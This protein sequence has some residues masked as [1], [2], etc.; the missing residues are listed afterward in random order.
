MDLNQSRNTDHERD[1]VPENKKRTTLASVE[2]QKFREISVGKG[3]EGRGSKPERHFP[4]PPL[5]DFLGRGLI[6]YVVAFS[7]F[8]VARKFQKASRLIIL[9]F[10]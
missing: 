2:K 6:F 4:R 5:D 3:K 8:H 10:W 9:I 7:L 1:A